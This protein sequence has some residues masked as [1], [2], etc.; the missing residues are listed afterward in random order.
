MPSGRLT[1]SQSQSSTGETLVLNV[2]KLNTIKRTSQEPPAD[3]LPVLWAGVCAGCSIATPSKVAPGN[4]HDTRPARVA[5]WEHQVSLGVGKPTQWSFLFCNIDSIKPA[6][7]TPPSSSL[8][9]LLGATFFEANEKVLTI[10][11]KAFHLCRLAKSMKTPSLSSIPSNG[12]FY[13]SRPIT[14]FP[15]HVLGRNRSFNQF[16]AEKADRICENID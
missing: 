11:G 8:V 4:D 12:L 2:G 15:L 6:A 14:R 10:S 1:S 3:P 9:P 13:P 7:S 5:V 16:R